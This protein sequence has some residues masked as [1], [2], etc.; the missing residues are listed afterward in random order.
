MYVHKEQRNTDRFSFIWYLI[1]SSYTT[2]NVLGWN[3]LPPLPFSCCLV[4][5]YHLLFTYSFLAHHHLFMW[6]AR[7]LH[8][9]CYVLPTRFLPICSIRK[10]TVSMLTHTHTHCQSS[11]HICIT[12]ITVLGW[13]LRLNNMGLKCPSVHPFTKCSFDFN[14]IWYV[15]TGR[16]VMHDSMQY[17][18]IQG[19][20][21]EPLKVRNSTIFKGC[22]LLYL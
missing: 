2:H 4:L 15:G 19:Q 21:H 8:P 22:L 6:R 16:W 13:L 17:D 10:F 3:S 12:T 18:P 5:P 14:E 7:A 20:G 1:T 9:Y 11:L